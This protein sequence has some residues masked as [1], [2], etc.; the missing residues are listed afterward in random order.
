MTIEHISSL[1]KNLTEQYQL[2]TGLNENRFFKIFYSRLLSSK[3]M[4]IGYNPGGDPAAWDGSTQ[5]STPFYENHEHEYV[6][7]NYPIAKAMRHFFLH[8]FG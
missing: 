2:Q 6:D 7:M 8:A 1:M 4:V 3:I 5:A